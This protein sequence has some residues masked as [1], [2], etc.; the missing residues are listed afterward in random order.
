MKMISSHGKAFGLPALKNQE[1]MPD[2]VFMLMSAKYM[3]QQTC[4]LVAMEN[5]L[6]PQ[7]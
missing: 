1:A 7:T 4:M 2:S 6:D 3:N 5:L